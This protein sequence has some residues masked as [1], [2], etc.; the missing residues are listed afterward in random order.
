MLAEPPTPAGSAT[1]HIGCTAS[2]YPVLMTTSP[3]TPIFPGRRNR[4]GIT[5]GF[6]LL[7]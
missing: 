1:R 7:C 3:S 4:R 5:A 6:S 2:P